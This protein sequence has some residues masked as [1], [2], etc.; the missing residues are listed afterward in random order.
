MTLLFPII[1]EYIFPQTLY[2]HR[3]WYMRVYIYIYIYIWAWDKWRTQYLMN[4]ICR[5]QQGL[6]AKETQV[7]G[8]RSGVARRPTVKWDCLSDVIVMTIPELA[9]QF[10]TTPSEGFEYVIV[11]M[12]YLRKGFHV[13]PYSNKECRMN[14]RF[15]MYLSLTWLALS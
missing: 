2:T 13:F 8:K 10:A 14:Q 4:L 15:S 5:E 1:C 6:R 11:L 9:N 12:G 3:G 7:K